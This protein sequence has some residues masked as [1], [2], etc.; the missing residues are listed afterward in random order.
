MAR[1][2]GLVALGGLMTVALSGC[3]AT[4]DVDGVAMQAPK[5]DAFTAALQTHYVE[6][7]RFERDEA[8]WHDV[9]YF[10]EKARMSAEGQA[11][12]PPMP[13]ARGVAGAATDA[14][15]QRLTAA[16]A[17]NAPS[18]T[19]DA[20]AKAQIGY[21]HWLEQ[22]EEGHQPDHIAAAKAVYDDAMP[23]CV[24]K[25]EP[26][27]AAPAPAPAPMSFIVHFP[28]DS[29]AIVDD[30]AAVIG[31]VV[32][33]FTD[34]KA[35]SVDVTAHTDTAGSSA[36]NDGLSERRATAVKNAL[37]KGGVPAQAIG[38][39]A[40][41]EAAPAVATGDNVPEAANRRATITVTP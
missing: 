5:G 1:K 40:K 22:L 37:V 13:S 24:A 25:V 31:K 3:A 34:H 2:L 33:F 9:A 6:S 38:T 29:A 4:W 12:Q 20:C 19:P 8:D 39:A 21:E 41:G 18:V 26:P 28:F 16:L 14:A 23:E 7:A 10:V 32:S 35:K 27:K 15:Y 17:T 36:Y 30:A 11:P